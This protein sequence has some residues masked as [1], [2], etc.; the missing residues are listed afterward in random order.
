MSDDNVASTPLAIGGGS[1]L[2]QIADLIGSTA[3]QPVAEQPVAEQTKQPKKQ[4]KNQPE[5]SDNGEEETEQEATD[6]DEEGLLE[7]G[8]QDGTEELE[9]PTEED[10]TWAKALGIDER[11]V[12][13]DE[14]GDLAGINVKVDGKVSTVG[15]SDLIQGYQSNRNNTNKS[16]ALAEQRKEFETIKTEVSKEYLQKIEMADKLVD[17]L[18]NS[19]LS[20]Y[21]NVDWQRLRVE[22]PGEYAATVQDYNLKVAEIE[23]LTSVIG[24]EKSSVATEQSKEEQAKIVESIQKQVELALEK[25]PSWA[26]PE[27]FR[28]VAKEMSDFVGE[29]YGFTP[30]EFA[31]V[32]DARLF[33]LV[34]DAMAY[35]NSI[36]TAKQKLDQSIPKFQ[37]STGNKKAPTSKLDKLIKQAKAATGSN[38]RYAQAN[39]VAELLSSQR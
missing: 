25:N 4:P 31:S 24:S 36:K 11:N 19:L 13:L 18:K 10:I 17:H 23:R 34:K 6:A 15:I 38:Q 26:K 33:E 27:V 9:E 21:Q 20:G 12:V 29:A 30:D 3:E 22:N 2:D 39:A 7:E 37:K 35:R 32:Q 1:M 8:D 5:E 16:K 28:K 14:N